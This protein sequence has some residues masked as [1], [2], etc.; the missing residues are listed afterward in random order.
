MEA[1]I[2]ALT[3][4]RQKDKDENQQSIQDPLNVSQEVCTEFNKIKIINLISTLLFQRSLS[5][6]KLIRSYAYYMYNVL[7]DDLS[8]FISRFYLNWVKYL[9]Y[10]IKKYQILLNKPLVF[11]ENIV[12]KFQRQGI[13]DWAD[14]S[15]RFFCMQLE[16]SEWISPECWKIMNVAFK[17]KN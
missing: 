2:K 8:I 1:S 5:C 3:S 10:C 15:P 17:W 9:F 4:S 6:L 12:F 7:V 11:P 13:G 16:L 14:F